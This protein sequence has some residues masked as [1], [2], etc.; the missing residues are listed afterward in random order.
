[1]DRLGQALRFAAW[2]L[3]LHVYAVAIRIPAVRRA[4]VALFVRHEVRFDRWLASIEARGWKK[5]LVSFE[6]EVADHRY[7]AVYLEDDEDRRLIARFPNL[8]VHRE[9]NIQ[10]PGSAHRHAWSSRSLILRGG[11]TELVD[12]VQRVHR[13]GDLVELSFRPHHEIIAC[14]PG[15]ITL[16]LHDYRVGRWWFRVAPCATLCDRCSTVYGRCVN[17][18]KVTPYELNAAEGG[19]WR[20]TTWFSSKTP[21][22]ERKIRIRRRSLQEHRVPIMSRDEA[23]ARVCEEKRL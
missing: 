14:E 2:Q 12:G 4:I 13:A 18:I 20:T 11:Y 22:L 10:T 21:G 15:T 6:G 5:L 7:Y 19:R 1:V 9:M 8:Y 17:E 16:F 3:A 23:L